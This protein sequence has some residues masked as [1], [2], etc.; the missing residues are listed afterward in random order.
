MIRVDGYLIVKSS[1][2]WLDLKGILNEFKA[3]SSSIDLVNR[4][5]LGQANG[6]AIREMRI[7]LWVTGEDWSHLSPAQQ[8]LRYQAKVMFER[9][10][11]STAVVPIV[12]VALGHD[13]AFQG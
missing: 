11:L 5:L 9:S 10:R 6:E 12:R 3:L 7:H 2:G 4:E 8:L 13:Y 1:F